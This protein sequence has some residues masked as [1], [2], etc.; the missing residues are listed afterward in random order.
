MSKYLSAIAKVI[1]FKSKT[2]KAGS[3]PVM[4]RITFK[5]KRKYFTTPFKM[6]D[7]EF[8]KL[9]SA[10]RLQKTDQNILTQIRSIEVRAQTTIDRII[11]DTR[12]FSFR[13][14]EDA[15]YTSAKDTNVLRL[16]DQR[17]QYYH[18][19]GSYS[20][21]DSFTCA[22]KHLLKYSKNNALLLEDITPEYLEKYERAHPKLS[23]NTLGIY[24]RNLRVIFN[25]AIKNGAIAP[26]L[27]P[28]NE[29]RPPFRPGRKKAL[30]K[31]D[32]IKILNHQTE[33]YS[34]RWLSQQVYIFS[35]LCNG[36]NLKDIAS[37]RWTDVNDGRI[38]FI[39]SKTI[40]T[41]ARPKIQSI[42]INE[43]LLK[44]LNDLEYYK[45]TESDYVF[46]ILNKGASDEEHYRRKN[47]FVGTINDNI[48]KIAKELEIEKDFT[49]YSARHSWATV[50]KR[51]G[52][53][54]EVISEGMTHS[55]VRVTEG[56]L[57]SFGDD[58]LDSVNE[59]LL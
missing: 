32:I 40:N 12:S 34:Y 47:D 16:F 35:Y 48:R 24:E 2:L 58:Q 31:E 46:P 49:F 36:M 14:F 3:H 21:R 45:T 25:L 39:R 42:K 29:H 43:P 37:L 27:N 38:Y 22:K 13:Q 52:V 5:G 50:L 23:P 4:L 18:E 54:V 28:F 30:I 26:E 55:S 53:S 57:D 41:S 59:F 1:L 9:F 20:T 8:E 17:I 11:E 44:I 10:K 51:E 56:Y 6:T 33:M 19:K 15:F 7:E